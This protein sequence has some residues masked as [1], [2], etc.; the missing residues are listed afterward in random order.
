MRGLDRPGCA[1][2]DA[3]WVVWNLGVDELNE[4]VSLLGTGDDGDIAADDGEETI[5]LTAEEPS[6][7]GRGRDGAKDGG[8]LDGIFGGEG[9]GGPVGENDADEADDGLVKGCEIASHAGADAARAIVAKLDDAAGD[10]SVLG[11]KE[12]VIVVDGVD[13]LSANWLSVTEGKVVVDAHCERR[14]AWK[15]AAFGLA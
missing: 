7:G 2:I 10:D 3:L 8:A 1:L 14:P 9:D 6:L 13:Q 4:P 11:E 15:S 12:F 5:E